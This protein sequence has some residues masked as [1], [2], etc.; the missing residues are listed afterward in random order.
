[1]PRPRLP[2]RLYQR[3]DGRWVIRDGDAEHGT[4]CRSARGGPAPDAARAALAAYLSPRARPGRAE[5]VAVADVLAAYAREIGPTLAAPASLAYA[6]RALAPWWGDLTCDAVRGETCRRYAAS[7]P[8]AGTARRE[9]GVLQAALNHA[10]REG[11]LLDLVPV[12]LPPA[13]P[14]GE[15]WLTR[16]ELRALLRASAPHLRRFIL[17]SVLTGRRASAVL[18]LRWLPSTDAG[19]V[20]LERGVIRFAGA[21]QRETRKRRGAVRAPDVLMRLLRRWAR[22]GGSHVIMHRGRPVTAIKTAFAAAIRRSGIADATP[23]DLKHTAVTWAFQRGM[24]R[25]DAA[26]WF[27]TTAAT[28]ERVYRQHSPDHQERARQIMGF[29]V[30]TGRAD[31]RRTR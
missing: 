16:A 9:L 23:H 1:M 17:L 6:I 12:T 29:R 11:R 5:Q 30:E 13:P 21:G 10:R 28:L 24:S 31:G 4:G 20:D 3:A 18:A 27:D 8:S 14:P 25:E 19:W 26:D 22:S 15:R 7:R 2:P